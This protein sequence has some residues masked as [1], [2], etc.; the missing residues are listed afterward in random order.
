MGVNIP[1]ALVEV[2]YTA[3]YCTVF[4]SAN[5]TAIDNLSTAKCVL[6]LGETTCRQTV[7]DKAKLSALELLEHIV[8]ACVHM[9]G[10][11]NKLTADI[12]I[13]SRRYNTGSSVSKGSHSIKKVSDMLYTCVDTCH[14]SLVIG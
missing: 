6:A 9:E 12:S 2:K 11:D 13:H 10:V 14:S 5:D 1:H 7:S 4:E 3:G 8:K